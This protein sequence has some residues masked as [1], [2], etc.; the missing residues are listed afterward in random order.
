MGKAYRAFLLPWIYVNNH[1]DISF[2]AYEPLK[3]RKSY[4]MEILQDENFKKLVQSVIFAPP[5]G[6][7]LG[8]K[9]MS[10]EKVM[11][12]KWMKNSSFC[13]N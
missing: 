3:S 13:A 9:Y 1:F 12:A 5:F 6:E 4:I 7:N 8:Q 2:M 10:Y 11:H